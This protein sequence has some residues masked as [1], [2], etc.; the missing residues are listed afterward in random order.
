SSHAVIWDQSINAG[1]NSDITGIRRDNATALDQRKSHTEM[2]TG[3]VRN[4]IVTIANGTNF[5][6]PNIISVDNSSLIWGHNNGGLASPFLPAGSYF[7][8]IN[9]EEI[10]SVF[11]RH[12]KS[13]ETGTI[14]T[15]TIEF[16]MSTV[17]GVGGVAGANDLNNIRLLVDADGTF[18]A[19]ATSISPSFV[20]NTNDIVRFEHNFVAGTG[21]YF[22][23]GSVDKWATPLPVE[24]LSFDV[25]CY[26]NTVHLNWVTKSEINNDFFTVEK[27]LDGIEFYAIG[28][29]QGNGNSNST[30]EYQWTDN[31]PTNGTSY[32]RLK[33]TDFNGKSKLHSVKAISCDRFDNINVYPNPTSGAVNIDFGKKLNEVSIK[34]NDVYGRTLMT[35]NHKSLNTIDLEIKGESGLYFIEI[36]AKN[37][38][39]KVIKVLKR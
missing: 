22:T 9:P 17:A 1:Y 25:S 30:A 2:W 29:I 31:N 28:K 14:G 35:E 4:D 7:F 16:D 34:I 32:Y 36:V 12:W 8:T 33:Q 19:G 21:F 38:N 24:L 23:I 5:T 20:D 13:Q 3:A 37:G 27:S 6:T 10:Q 15:V 11:Q 26:N 18:T 39:Q